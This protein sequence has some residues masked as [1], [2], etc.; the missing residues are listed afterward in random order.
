MKFR[1]FRFIFCFCLF[2]FFL[3]FLFFFGGG[4]GALFVGGLSF[5]HIFFYSVLLSLGFVFLW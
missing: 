2:I 1:F 4:G 3:S 5:F